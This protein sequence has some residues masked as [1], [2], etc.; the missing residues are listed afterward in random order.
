MQH[1]ACELRRTRLLK[2][3]GKSER[4]PLWDP[5]SQQNGARSALIAALRYQKH[6]RQTPPAIFQTVS[7]G[8]WVNSGGGSAVYR[9]TSTGG[10]IPNERSHNDGRRRCEGRSRLLRRVEDQR[11]R[12]HALVGTR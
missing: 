6:A 5:T 3:F 7:L 8:G 11:L 12:H 1:P 4:A 10:P 9:V 2:L